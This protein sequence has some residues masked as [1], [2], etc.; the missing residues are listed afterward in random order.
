MFR[1]LP[2]HII[3]FVERISHRS[4]IF[5]AFV[6]QTVCSVSAQEPVLVEMSRSHTAQ[7][8][9]GTINVIARNHGVD[10]ADVHFA[11]ML[12]ASCLYK[13][14][15]QCFRSEDDVFESRNLFKTVDEYIHRTFFLCQWYLTDT[16]PVLIAFREHIRFFYH[17]AFQPEQSLFNR[18][19]FIITI[20]RGSFHL[21][22]TCCFVGIPG[23]VYGHV[24]IRQ[25]PVAVGQLLILLRD[26]HA[27]DKVDSGFFRQV[28]CTFLNGVC[29][30]IQ[31]IQMAGES[32]V[33]RVLRNK[34]EVDTFAFV[35]H[36]CIHQIIFIK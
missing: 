19:E 16:R 36:Q 8:E 30:I 33:L 22:S 3:A 21:Q 31:Y 7:P 32:E 5:P 6:F 20:F 27:V 9:T 17:A 13:V 24:I 14:L 1:E 10:R 15:N 23:K 11:R 25:Y 28:H 26:V 18:I 34:S 29:R 2:N 12:F 4:A 35:Y